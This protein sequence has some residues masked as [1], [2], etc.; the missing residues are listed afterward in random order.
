MRVP[1]RAPADFYPLAFAQHR[2]W[3]VD[4]LGSGHSGYNVG[5]A[6]RLR[7]RLDRAALDRAIS[8]IIRRH[9]ILRTTYVEVDGVPMQRIEAAA[10]VETPVVDLTSE[11]PV[12]DPSGL[13]A[14]V[15]DELKAPLDLSRHWS[16]RTRL[17]RLAPDDHILTIVVHHVATDT[18]TLVFREISVLYEAFSRGA[19]SPLPELPIQ[20]ADYAVWERQLL[21]GKYLDKLVSYWT[22]QLTGAPHAIRLPT[23]RPR[24][25]LLS[26]HGAR[27]HFQ[28]TRLSASEV[29]SFARAEG[30][31]VYATLLG[32]FAVVLMHYSQQSDI[33][34]SGPVAC[35]ELPELEPLIGCFANTVVLRLDLSGALTFRQV[36][37]RATRAVWG[38]VAHRRLPFHYMV[39]IVKPPRDASRVPL[40]QVNFRV[41]TPE[42]FPLPLIEVEFL[43][44]HNS[45]AKFE[46]AAQFSDSGDGFL[47]YSTDLF[48]A[49]RIATIAS[50]FETILCRLLARPD[51]PVD[52]SEVRLSLS[53]APAKSLKTFKR[54]GHSE[55]V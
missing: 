21:T 52:S 22:K 3:F 23:D 6:V 20:Y 29:H 24:P 30:T 47:D 26:T 25:A 9:E 38:A 18:M 14:I 10:T 16:I 46:L 12:P 11:S 17:L 55:P 54:R 2:L 32:A 50:D 49:E 19:A 35:R 36:A 43:P 53:A 15:E 1:R 48:T 42:P 40:V 34:I 45:G 5:R 37:E 33:L 8:E 31:T 41:A 28:M 13:V 39:D 44:V 51:V 27:H 4:Q 7:G